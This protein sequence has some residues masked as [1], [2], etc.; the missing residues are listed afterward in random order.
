MACTLV[1]GKDLRV[2]KEQFRHRQGPC[3]AHC[4]RMENHNRLQALCLV[5]ES[6][7][8]LHSAP[9]DLKPALHYPWC[10]GKVK[11]VKEESVHCLASHATPLQA[12]TAQG[13]NPITLQR[14]YVLQACID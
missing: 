10:G 14:G 13:S 2:T 11:V 9:R 12:G 7:H 8:H 6:R 3:K 4:P 1:A 5:P